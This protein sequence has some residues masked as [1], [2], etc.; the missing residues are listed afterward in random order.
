MAHLKVNF[1]YVYLSK[2]KIKYIPDQR[3]CAFC[4][5]FLTYIRHFPFSCIT[6]RFFLLLS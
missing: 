4:N 2:I 6:A 5:S 3:S 1:L